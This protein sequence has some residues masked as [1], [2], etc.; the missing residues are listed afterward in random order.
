MSF[1]KH[2][3]SNANGVFRPVARISQ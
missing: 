1:N 2:I 3:G